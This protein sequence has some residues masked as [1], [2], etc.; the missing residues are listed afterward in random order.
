MMEELY[1]KIA[2]VGRPA[3]ELSFSDDAIIEMLREADANGRPDVPITPFCGMPIIIDP[4]LD[5][6][7]IVVVTDR[8][9]VTIKL[10]SALPGPRSGAR[11]PLQPTDRKQER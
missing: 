1:R 3:R 8:E 4:E 10:E 11:R 5:D 6:D 2:H 7:V 9:K